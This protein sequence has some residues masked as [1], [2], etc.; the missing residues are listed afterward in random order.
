MRIRSVGLLRWLAGSDALE[1]DPPFGQRRRRSL[2]E[3]AFNPSVT[4]SEAAVFA[5]RCGAKGAGGEM[6]SC[7]EAR[8]YNAPV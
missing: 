7:A 4:Q 2:A 1:R 8:F 6:T 3:L 5:G